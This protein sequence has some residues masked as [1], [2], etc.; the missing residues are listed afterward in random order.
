MSLF[1][2]H[3]SISPYLVLHTQVEPKNM[4]SFTPHLMQWKENTWILDLSPV[5][6][7]WR[8]PP[9]PD[10]D[11]SLSI[12][13]SLWLQITTG[14]ASATDLLTDDRVAFSGS[15]LKLLSFFGL[16]SLPTPGFAIV[17]P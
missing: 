17:E 2:S 5:L 8:R 6:N 10:A 12:P 13:L 14:Q 16:L 1:N 3:Q 7:Y 9:A 4:F 11:A 15:R